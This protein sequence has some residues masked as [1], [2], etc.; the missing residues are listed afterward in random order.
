MQSLKSVN[1]KGKHCDIVISDENVALW[2]AF[3][4]HRA[5]VAVLGNEDIDIA[6]SKY[7]VYDFFDIDEEYLEKVACRHLHIPVCIGK[8]DDIKIRELCLDDFDS[9]SKF[10]E[11]PFKNIEGLREY[12]DFHYD[13]Y[14]YGLYVFENEK[15]VMGLAGFY[16]EDNRCFLSY[17]TDK[18]YRKRGYTFK[19][20]KYLLKYIEKKIGVRDVYTRI[21]ISN[22]ASIKLAD[23]LGVNIV[24]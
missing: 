16:N 13:F 4:S 8:V 9:L 7:A 22:T 5:T 1:I 14:G 19:V 3:N 23:K 15:E 21:D 20:C 24:N 2:E 6:V 17:M 18:K 10:C 12:I 11:F